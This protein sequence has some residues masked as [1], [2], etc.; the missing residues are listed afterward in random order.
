ME[1]VMIDRGFDAP[2]SKEQVDSLCA[3][4]GDQTSVADAISAIHEQDDAF[5]LKRGEFYPELLRAVLT[6]KKHAATAYGIGTSQVQANYGSNGSIDTILAAVKVEETRRRGPN[7]AQEGGVLM[8]S[9]TYFRNY[10]SASAKN[11]RTHFVPLRSDFA[12][13][14]EAFVAAMGRTKPSIVVLVTP[15]NPTGIAIPDADLYSVLDNLTAD[16]WAMIDR[17]LVNVRSEVP[18]RE[19]LHEYAAKNV[20]VLHSFSKY[21]GMSH[22]R[23]GIA[24]HS[25]SSLAAKVQPHLPLGIGLEGCLKAIQAIMEEGTMRPS[26]HIISNITENHQILREFVKAEPS[27]AFTD[28]TGNYCLLCLPATLPS[29]YVTA[30][31][32]KD[33]LIVMGGHEFPEPNS[34]VV[35]LHTGGCPKYTRD[36]CGVLRRLSD[37][38]RHKN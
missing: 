11:L 5:D 3:L 38:G 30:A 16:S 9:P 10:N 34:R 25:N 33:G 22:L 1:G 21:K 7:A 24:L 13:D 4:F 32:E 17:T 6:L 29:E 26:D 2:F 8:T 27:F 23:I 18:T 35:R 28:F 19:L 14:A 37:A 12:F 15:N 20:V 31:L 36:L